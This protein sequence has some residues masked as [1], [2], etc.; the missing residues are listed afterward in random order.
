MVSEV[1][2]AY[3]ETMIL[4]CFWADHEGRHC[5]APKCALAGWPFCMRGMDAQP[6]LN[7]G[8]NWHRSSTFSLSSFIEV[9]I[10]W[11]LYAEFQKSWTWFNTQ[12][13][14]GL[15]MRQR[16]IG[17]SIAKGHIQVSNGFYSLLISLE[18]TTL[19]PATFRGA[20]AKTSFHLVGTSE[21]S[22]FHGP[23][24]DDCLGSCFRDASANSVSTLTVCFVGSP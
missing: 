22:C 16:C 1:I 19:P 13:K 15:H 7:M 9:G 2:A 6:T 5:L 20:S 21:I 3:L 8:Q 24:R 14:E 4:P 17:D 12:I 18:I 10:S 23:F 11:R